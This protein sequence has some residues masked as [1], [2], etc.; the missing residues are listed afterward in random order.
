MTTSTSNPAP[1]PSL[2]RRCF[3]WPFS[4]RGLR[5]IL[6][7]AVVVATLIGLFFAVENWRGRRAWDAYRQQAEAKGVILDFSKLIPPQVPDDQNF[8]MTPFLKPLLDFE[9][10]TQKWRDKEAYERVMKFGAMFLNE[11][12]TDAQEKTRTVVS[13]ERHKQMNGD[14]RRGWRRDMVAIYLLHNLDT[15]NTTR[16]AAGFDP[17]KLDAKAAATGLIENMS[18]F[19]P[20]FAELREAAKRPQSRFNI[21]YEEEN[22]AGI[23]LPHLAKLKNLSQL[24]SYRASAELALGRTDEA[25]A[26]VLLVLRLAESIDTERTLIAYLVRIAI[27]NIAVQ[28]AWEGLAD[29]RWNEAQLQ[30][31]AGA[32]GRVDVMGGLAYALAGERGFGNSIIDYLRRKPE[33]WNSLASPEG[34]PGPG[35]AWVFNLMPSG[36]FLFERVNYNELFDSMLPPTMGQVERQIDPLVYAKKWSEAEAGLQK[37]TAILEH[38]TLSRLLIPALSKVVQKAANTDASIAE[39]RTALALERYSLANKSYPEALSALV[40]SFLPAEPKDV[41]K[42]GP[43]KYQRTADGRYQL[44]SLGWNGVDDGGKRVLV[45][46]GGKRLADDG[47]DWVWSYSAE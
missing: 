44:Y 46:E 8:A 17:A 45:R 24:L 3:G 4:R 6:F 35:G 31:L 21:H 23:L 19:V 32:F 2:F 10:G 28:P 11:L 43:L 7:A 39:A 34:G 18:T 16:L 9:P 36:W 20:V 25:L 5:S 1:R 26:D 41:I 13:K 47:G 40:P 29:R 37:A 38:R 15:N 27:L 42:G 33:M 30:T 12:P 22:T 14:W